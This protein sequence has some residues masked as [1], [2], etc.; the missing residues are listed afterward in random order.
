M[1][2]QRLLL[3]RFSLHASPCCGF[4]SQSPATSR[5][6]FLFQVSQRCRLLYP[7]GWRVWDGAA[8]SPVKESKD[9]DSSLTQFLGELICYVDV[10]FVFSGVIG[11]LEKLLLSSRLM[12]RV[13]RPLLNSSS[14]HRRMVLGGFLSC[15]RAIQDAAQAPI[16]I[17]P[18]SVS[19]NTSSK[20]SSYRSR[21]RSYVGKL[22]KE[23]ME[24]RLGFLLDFGEF[25][26]PQQPSKYT[27]GSMNSV[28]L[29]CSVC[30]I[31]QNFPFFKGFGCHM[32]RYLMP[33]GI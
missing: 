18:C 7:C 8:P 30:L 33:I 2:R 19:F 11:Y 26:P 20:P 27:F 32:K 23:L 14:V 13:L 9:V 5:H 28:V 22:W 10:L 16:Y 24:N 12:F 3:C 1:A 31:F 21:P 15:Q 6:K 29:Y 17:H 4:S 25:A